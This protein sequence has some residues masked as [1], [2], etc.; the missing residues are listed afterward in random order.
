MTGEVFDE[1]LA[2]AGV[3]LELHFGQFTGVHGTDTGL[4]WIVDIVAAEYSEQQTKGDRAVAHAQKLLVTDRPMDVEAG[5]TRQMPPTQNM[6][7]CCRP[8]VS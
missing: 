6:P 5:T 2:E 1:H 3:T 4:N 8:K 7:L